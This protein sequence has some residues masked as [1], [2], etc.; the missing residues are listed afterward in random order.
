M[1]LGAPGTAWRRQTASGRAA[2]ALADRARKVLGGIGV[3]PL[4]RDLRQG[5]GSHPSSR[6][7][8]CEP[9]A[10]AA[11]IRDLVRQDSSPE[12]PDS[13]AFGSASGM[14]GRLPEGRYRVTF[15]PALRPEP[16]DD[17]AG[18]A[19]TRRCLAVCERVI[20]ERPERWLWLHDRWKRP[21]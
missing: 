2:G 21:A 20:R 14:T 9:E 7:E 17:D 4:A 11:P 13:L 12:I 15:L 1:D 19:L 8:R 3:S 6:T 16:S 10:S 5:E 18:E